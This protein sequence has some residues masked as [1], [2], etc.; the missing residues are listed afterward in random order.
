M[1]PEVT[2]FMDDQLYRGNRTTKRNA[3][4]FSAFNSY[5]YPA[6][7]RAGVRITYQKQYIHYPNPGSQLH[8][9][10]KTDCNVAVLKLFPGITEPVVKA[11]LSTPGL[12]GVVLETYG[13]GN[14][15]SCDWLYQDLRDA[16]KRGI[17][18]VNKTQCNTGS[19]SMGQY[20][21]SLP[22]LKAGVVSGYDITTEALLT[23]MMY[24]FGENPD[25]NELVKELLQ[26][27][28]CGELTNN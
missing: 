25:N 8:L 12:R 20:A 27:P 6:L 28:L 5:N 19:V 15:P 17:I 24:L 14:A 7:A 9:R 2:I 4:H 1:V 3:E 18:I 23:K 13:A 10:D 16:V 21:V 22:L 11:I 26:S